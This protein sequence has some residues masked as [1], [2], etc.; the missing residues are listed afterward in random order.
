SRWWAVI[1]SMLDDPDNSFWDDRDTDEVETRD[2]II[3]QA[4]LE[5]RDELTRLLSRDPH[6][7]EWGKLHQLELVNPTLG[8]NSSPVRFMFNRGRYEL[9]G[10][11]SLVDAVSWDA[12]EDDY[13]VTT[14]PSMR[15]IVPL[16]DLDA[17]RWIN[18]TGASGHAYNDHYTD[19]TALW[20][21]GETLAWF[22]T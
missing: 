10:A 19:Q 13:D 3:K 1:E 4:L 6:R 11:P 17:S 21:D 14:V 7:W 2:D 22:F 5:A 18:L 9:G 15:M 20:A 8:S 16:D 12:S